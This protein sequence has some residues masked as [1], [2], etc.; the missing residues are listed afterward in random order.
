K[1]ISLSP[2]P[3]KTWRTCGATRDRF[4]N[5]WRAR[6]VSEDVAMWCAV[7]MTSKPGVL[8]DSANAI[9]AMRYVLPTCR[10]RDRPTPSTVDAREPSARFARISDPTCSCH[11]SNSMPSFSTQ[12]LRTAGQPVVTAPSG[13]DTARAI[14][15]S[16]GV[17]RGVFRDVV[18]IRAFLLGP[19]VQRLDL[20][21]D[22]LKSPCERSEVAGRAVRVG[23]GL[24]DPLAH[25][26][27]EGAVVAGRGSLRDGQ[28]LSLLGSLA[29]GHHAQRLACG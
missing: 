4:A 15:E 23:D 17:E 26:D 10:G 21:G 11:G 28:L 20:L 29:R 27:Q 22:I 19:Q 2:E 3:V 5:P 24:G 13:A 8:T 25:G 12:V 14:S 1:R 18:G 6:N 7:Q 16:R 9:A